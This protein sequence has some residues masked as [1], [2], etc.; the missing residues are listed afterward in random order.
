ME[1]GRQTSQTRCARGRRSRGHPLDE[2]YRLI[3]DHSLQ[4]VFIAQGAGAVFINQPLAAMLG[5]TTEELLIAAKDDVAAFTHPE[6]KLLLRGRY[7][8]RM[9][10]KDVPNTY[11]V[12]CLHKDGSVR[13]IELRAARINYLGQPA[14]LAV[15]IDVTDRKQAEER[16]R[17][18]EASMRLA[19]DLEGAAVWDFDVQQRKVSTDERAMAALG[20]TPGHEPMTDRDW[21]NLVH[22]EDLPQMLAALETHLLGQSPA[23]EAEFRVRH[24]RGHYVWGRARGMVIERDAL[25]TPLRVIGTA[26]EISERKKAEQ[27]LMEYQARLKALASELARA[28][29]Q[30]RRRIATIL[31]DQIGQGLV[32]CKLLVDAS[33]QNPRPGEAPDRCAKISQILDGLIE[34]TQVL[35][36]DLGNPTLYELGLVP[37]LEEW[38]DEEIGRQYTALSVR[39]IDEGI[40]EMREQDLRAL[41]F[42]SVKELVFN[43]VK[44]AGARHVEVRLRGGPDRTEVLVSD[45]GIGFDYEQTRGQTG[46][47]G[48]FGLFSIRE[49]IED[50]GGIFKV[51]SAKGLGTQILLAVPVRTCPTQ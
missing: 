38:L 7:A 37:A 28:E 33:L 30:E 23:F 11:T 42:R 20:L 12:R 13:W 32:S 4:A 29:E 24:A 47:K 19:L 22:R 25:G 39:L 5:Y 45:D 8:D 14:S 48:G 18:S 27:Q 6:D 10:G 26:V 51:D 43:V 40:V 21:Y 17:Q 34:Q 1:Q 9:A 35:N 15:G 41:L 50:I 16:L 3:V 36:A 2:A 49:R 46:R 44:H 31:H